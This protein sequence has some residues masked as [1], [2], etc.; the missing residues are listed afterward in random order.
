MK[1][2]DLKFISIGSTCATIGVLGN[3]RIKGPVD[4]LAGC[5]GTICFE[6]LFNG[7]FISSIFENQPIITDKKPGY[8]GDSDKYYQYSHYTVC[9]NNPLENSYRKELLKR[10]QTFLDFKK[11]INNDDHYFIYSLGSADVN[12]RTHELNVPH[13]EKE[14]QYLKDIGVV[15]KTIFVGTRLVKNKG[16]WDFYGK[17][18][19]KIFPVLYVEIEDLNVWH[20]ESTQAQFKDQVC[21]LLGTD[22]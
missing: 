7:K 4:N 5:K 12:K 20:T 16:N 22:C 21:K 2:D 10:Y 15:N 11:D 8:E 18:F 3:D 17:D 9:H 1:F 14:I 13:I 6:V 19:S